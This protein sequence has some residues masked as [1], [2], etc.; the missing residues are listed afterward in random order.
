MYAQFKVIGVDVNAD[1]TRKPVC[2]CPVCGQ[3]QLVQPQKLIRLVWLVD[4][5][6]KTCANYKH[7][8]AIAEN[9]V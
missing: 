9:E 1:G 7:T 3:S 5:V 2:T 6:N 4:C 8:A